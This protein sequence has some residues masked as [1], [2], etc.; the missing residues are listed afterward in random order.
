M[1]TWG[2]GNFDN[3]GALDFVQELVHQLATGIDACF[4][5][6]RAAL[7]EDGEGTLV[8]SVAILTLLAKHCGAAV[9]QVEFVEG[10]KTR[11][12]AVFDDE[13]EGLAPSGDF[14]VQRRAVIEQTFN[15]LLEIAKEQELRRRQ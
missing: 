11:Y 2:G 13:I 14:A 5:E 6:D 3:D 9:P 8:P 7:D 1:G 4:G 15:E 12:L 10:W